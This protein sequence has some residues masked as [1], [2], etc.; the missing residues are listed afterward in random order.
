MAKGMVESELV[1]QL[2]V[3]A[4]REEA[5]VDAI[6]GVLK[7]TKGGSMHPALDQNTGCKPVIHGPPPSSAQ[8]PRR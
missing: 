2:L 8:H 4:E 5:L 3:R 1:A 7:A 6:V